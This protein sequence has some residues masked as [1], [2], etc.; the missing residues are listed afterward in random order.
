MKITVDGN[1]ATAQIAYAFS[2]IASI[3]PITPSTPMAENADEWQSLYVFDRAAKTEEVRE[4]NRIISEAFGGSENF[5][6]FCI[7]N[8]IK[9]GM[10]Y[11][12]SFDNESDVSQETL[13]GFNFDSIWTER[14]GRVMLDIFTN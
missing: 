7:E 10:L 9:C 3:Y 8:N 12:Y 13:E 4:I 11:C 1:T 6:N 14:D 2:E 5:I